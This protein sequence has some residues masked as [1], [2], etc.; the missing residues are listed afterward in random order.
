MKCAGPFQ[1]AVWS[2][3]SPDYLHAVL[4]QAVPPE[5]RLVFVWSRERCVRRFDP[6][7]QEHYFVKDLRKVKRIGFDLARVLI[8]D[9]TPKKL[10]RNY[11]NAVYVKPFLGDSDDDELPW[12]A[13]YLRTMVTADDVRQIE[14]RGWRSSLTTEPRK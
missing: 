5:V 1:L 4:A 10:E 6:E 13:A 3:S 9:D 11:G 14:K 12:L 7:L 2:S 8:V